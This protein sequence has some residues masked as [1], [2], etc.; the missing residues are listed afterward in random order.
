MRATFELNGAAA[1]WEGEPRR[2]LLDAL[3]D[4]LALTGT[5]AGCEHGVC[6]ACTVLVDGVAVR[7]CLMLA[8][9]ATGR[10]VT[11]IE[12]ITP[13]DGLHPVQ[14][15][16]RR[17]HGLQCGFCTPGMVL[18]LIDLLSSGRLAP[19]LHPAKELAGHLCRCT[20][21]TG[22]VAAAEELADDAGLVSRP[23]EGTGAHGQTDRV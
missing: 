7:A 12:G 15:A 19:G 16:L 2:S 10:R 17:H 6:G 23:P 18:G 8:V 14:D 1:A 21:Y 13:A 4:D 5:H 3:R 22:I 9:Q 11:T 20:G